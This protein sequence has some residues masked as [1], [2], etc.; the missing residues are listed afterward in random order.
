MGKYLIWAVILPIS[1]VASPN[2]IGTGTCRFAHFSEEHP[3]PIGRDRNGSVGGRSCADPGSIGIVA[4]C[5]N[6]RTDLT[7]C[8]FLRFPGGRF[9]LAKSAWRR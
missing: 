5:K 7:R 9:L 6:K 8:R 2:Q 1:S 4:Y 3:L